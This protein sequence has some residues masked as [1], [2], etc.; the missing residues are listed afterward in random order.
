MKPV[1][2]WSTSL[3]ICL[4]LLAI[5]AAVYSSVRTHEFVEYDDQAYVTENPQVQAGL[6]WSGLNW[7]FT[8]GWSGNWHPVTWLSHMLDT[9]MFGHSAVGPHCTN[10][11]LH[12]SSTLL[13]FLMLW[14]VT[15]ALWRSAAVATLFAVHPLHVESVA[16]VAERKDVLSGLFF[17]LT[18]WAYGEHALKSAQEL[19]LPNGTGPATK[20]SWKTV[21]PYYWLSLV[22]FTL[23]LMSKPML[24]TVPCVLLLLDFW[25]LSRMR[26]PNRTECS[27]PKA[28]RASLKTE[29]RRVGSLLLEK[30]PFFVLSILSCVVTFVAQKQAG[31][32]LLMQ[33][34]PFSM[35]MENALLA[36]TEYLRKMFWPSDLTALYPFPGHIS[37]YSV[38]I[39]VLVLA[40]VTWLV[41]TNARKRPYLV[42][43]WL[44]F[45]GMLVPVIGL[46]QV[47]Y[48]SMADRYTYLPLIGIFIMLSWWAGELASSRPAWQPALATVGAV[49]LLVFAGM[50]SNQLSYWQNTGTLFDHAL[51]VTSTNA[52]AH[53]EV[54]LSMIRKGDY[55]DALNHLTES[56]QINPEYGDAHNNLGLLLVSKGKVDEGLEEYRRAQRS[57]LNKGE[58]YFNIGKAFEVKNNLEAAVEAFQ[59]ALQLKPALWPA[60]RE[61]AILFSRQGKINDAIDQLKE[62]ARLHPDVESEYALGL[63]LAMAGQSSQAVLH[64]RK[65]LEFQPDSVEPLNDLAWTLATDPS[66]E[67]RNP[68]EAVQLAEKAC[69]LTQRREARFLGTLDAAYAAAGKYDDAVK[70]AKETMEVA[71]KANQQQVISA[72]KERLALYRQSLPYRQNQASTPAAGIDSR[73]VELH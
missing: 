50:T 9:Q 31:A 23:G 20:N 14:R 55:E 2:G 16:W 12:V 69:S 32:M 24:V 39:A 28:W 63:T 13:L 67:V 30:T 27:D 15:G 3:L 26:L 64:F 60:A 66:S 52:V 51:S 33:T 29:G 72:A 40:A 36:Y 18:L 43:G 37:L 41:F 62:V 17:M 45:I 19:V 58:L 57:N 34:V 8:T 70:T 44:W 49:V 71:A 59:R 1:S 11:F 42:V 21:T 47:G 10:L 61:L 56:V 25:P 22:C 53:Y 68:Q 48:Q 54:A 65:A 6:T 46:V 5:T 73:H 35:R 4:V 7:A 38:A